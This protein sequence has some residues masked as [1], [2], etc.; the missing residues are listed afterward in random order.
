MAVPV[1][2]TPA[3]SDPPDRILPAPMFI[4][5]VPPDCVSVNDVPPAS[6][7]VVTES[8][9]GDAMLIVE[10]ALKLAFD[11]FRAALVSVI[12]M[13]VAFTLP[14]TVTACGFS[15]VSVTL[16]D[17]VTGTAL[18]KLAAEDWAIV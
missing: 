8:P 2:S 5:A 10:V 15:P 14:P 17:S 4:A 9:A 18:L 13:V 16:N 12:D 11:T 3:A 7:E 6:W 1:G